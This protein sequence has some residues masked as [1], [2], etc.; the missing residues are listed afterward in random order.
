MAWYHWQ[1]HGCAILLTKQAGQTFGQFTIL[2]L[3]T[4]CSFRLRSEVE[5]NIL[6]EMSQC[7][8]QSSTLSNCPQHSKSITRVHKVNNLGN[9]PATKDMD[10]VKSQNSKRNLT[11][12]G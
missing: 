6:H 9:H 1:K 2:L 8:E 4:L 11:L 3:A 10:M 12:L 7:K 5:Q